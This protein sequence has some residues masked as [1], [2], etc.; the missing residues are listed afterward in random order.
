MNFLGTVHS[1]EV[2]ILKFKFHLIYFKGSIYEV[3]FCT[4]NVIQLTRVEDP[5]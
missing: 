4:K 3:N 2:F 5:R 1:V